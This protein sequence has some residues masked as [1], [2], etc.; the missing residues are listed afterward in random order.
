MRGFPGSSLFRVPHLSAAG[1]GSA[2]N[3]ALDEKENGLCAPTP[4]QGR[5]QGE[6]LLSSASDSKQI[7]S[8]PVL[9][10]R[11]LQGTEDTG[12]GSSC[13]TRQLAAMQVVARNHRS[14]LRTQG[15]LSCCEVTHPREGIAPRGLE[16]STPPVGL[17]DTAPGT[18]YTSS[19]QD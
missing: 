17:T 12:S 3:S 2:P 5:G 16:P 1:H 13:S 18:G 14:S 10:A 9:D 6:T 11:G 15:E 4:G 8:R 19:A 7:A